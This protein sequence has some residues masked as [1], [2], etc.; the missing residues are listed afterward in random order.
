MKKVLII[1]NF[2]LFSSSLLNAQNYFTAYKNGEKS[3]E[4]QDYD[5]A[6]I[7]FT[8]VLESKS[9]HDRALNYRGL[10]YEGINE[11]EKAVTDFKEAIT[12]KTKEADYYFNLGRVY[13]KLN[14]FKEAEAELVKAID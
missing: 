11:F 13:Y 10:C 14:K 8:K 1:F 2:L 4:S 9:N 6:I 7:E 12:I 5:N 3:Y